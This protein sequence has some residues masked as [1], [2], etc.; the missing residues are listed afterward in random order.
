M[1]VMTASDVSRR[2]SA[3]LDEAERGETIVVTRGGRRIAVVSP[4]SSANGAAL[5]AFSARWAGVLDEDFEAA[6][7]SARDGS[8]LD[9]DPWA[10]G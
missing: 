3:V 8:E 1:K 7:A 10:T 2:F 5:L 6:V 9:G 4:A